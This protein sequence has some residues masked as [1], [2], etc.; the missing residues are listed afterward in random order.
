MSWPV[1]ACQPCLLAL[2]AD[3]SR[4]ASLFQGG[5]AGKAEQ[6]REITRSS[7]NSPPK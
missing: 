7:H 3:D 5:V 1:L 4:V 2:T 6:G